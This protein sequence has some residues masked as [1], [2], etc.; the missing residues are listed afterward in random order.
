MLPITIPASEEYDANNNTIIEIPGK[1]IQLEH[2]LISVSKWESIWHKSFMNTEL[3]GEEL[4]SYVKCMTI[5]SNIPDKVYYGLTQK[6]LDD[7]I[8]YIKDPMTATTI[9]NPEKKTKS[10]DIITS[11]LVYYWMIS[12]QIPMEC[13]KWHFNRLMTLIE[14]CNIKSETP[15]K[16]SKKDIMS[17]NRQLN[18][19]RR[20]KHNSKG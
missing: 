17:R 14:V 5:N 10:R 4:I 8:N 7:I 1:T 3:K 9:N 15:K 13:E 11:E 16:M 2:S 19:A 6:N 12:L 20:A 18:A